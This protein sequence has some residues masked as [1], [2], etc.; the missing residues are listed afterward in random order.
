M[1]LPLPIAAGFIVY[2]NLIR[3]EPETGSG[4]LAGEAAGQHAENPVQ[5]PAVGTQP[6]GG[7]LVALYDAAPGACPAVRT[8]S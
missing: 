8:K 2:T 6:D 3:H 1:V 7:V 5:E 4:E